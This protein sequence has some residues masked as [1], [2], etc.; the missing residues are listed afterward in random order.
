M[1]T[2]CNY[3]VLQGYHNHTIPV[4][5][6]TSPSPAPPAKLEYKGSKIIFLRFRFSPP[7]IAA[8]YIYSIRPHLHCAT[9]RYKRRKRTEKKRRRRDLGSDIK[10]SSND[11]PVE[12]APAPP[13]PQIPNEKNHSQSATGTKII[14]MSKREGNLVE[15][16][17]ALTHRI[18]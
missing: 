1:F 11:S 14:A 15:K 2:K 5:I 4:R 3:Y 7:R 16:E 17:D 9:P 8:V 6:F 10:K 18:K 13:V 12:R